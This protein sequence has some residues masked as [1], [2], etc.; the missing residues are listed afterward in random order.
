MTE[1]RRQVTL[2]NTNSNQVLVRTVLIT[3]ESG[4]GK[5]HLA[6]VVAAHREFL[7]LAARGGSDQILGRELEPYLG[8]FDEIHLPALPNELIESELFGHVKGAFTG[9]QS[10]KVGLLSDRAEIV[11]SDILLDE[12]GDASPWL[13][14]KLLQVAETGSFRP[15][16]AEP[17]DNEQTSARIFF[18]TNR[19]LEDDVYAG[20]F[21]QDLYW[22]I[23][24][25][26]LQ[27]PP[28]RSQPENIAALIASLIS[29]LRAGLPA[30]LTANTIPELSEHDLSWARTFKWP[31]NIRQLRSSLQRWL[32]EYGR[33][34]LKSLVE[35]QPEFH[36]GLEQPGNSP[37]FAAL[38]NGE[39]VL[40]LENLLEL[41]AKDVRAQIIEWFD[42]EKPTD[43]RLRAIFS[44]VKPRSVRQKISDW[45]RELARN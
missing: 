23:A 11:R 44:E 16:G 9:A 29:Q 18:A 39:R 15:V 17:G 22:R 37:A 3:G 33:K 38:K 20:R 21:R 19:N 43:Q 35:A 40:S 28:L 41:A 27:V 7:E 42:Q 32:F 10:E 25:F 36:E 45:K 31:G 1:L 8:H 24:T 2:L 5:N 26:R 12:I 13:Q 14:A 4:S 30:D 34:S 6:R